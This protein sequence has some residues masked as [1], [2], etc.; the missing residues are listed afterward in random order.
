MCSWKIAIFCVFCP[1]KIH[2][3]AKCHYFTFLNLIHCR[4][5]ARESIC[6]GR[7]KILNWNESSQVNSKRVRSSPAINHLSLATVTCIHLSFNFVSRCS[8]QIFFLLYPMQNHI[9]LSTNNCHRWKRLPFVRPYTCALSQ[10]EPFKCVS[11]PTNTRRH[12][13]ISKT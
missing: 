6:L 13:F 3:N 1:S 11:T 4:W 10:F 5:I 9:G 7:A 8:L 2:S 12:T